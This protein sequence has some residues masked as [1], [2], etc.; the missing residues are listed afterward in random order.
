V[1]EPDHVWRQIEALLRGANTTATLVAPFIKKAVFEAA[2][3][4][5]PSSVERID[6]VTRWTPAEVAAGVSDPEILDVSDKDQRVRVALCPSLHA[7]IYCADDLCLIGSANLTGKATGLAPDANIEL[8]I[9]ARVSHPEVQRVL[10]ELKSAAVPATT[11]M[12][13]LVRQQA[14][15]LNNAV[16]TP[17][18]Q[19]TVS[20]Y[21]VTRR[22]ENL[23]TF[24]SGRSR[25]AVAVE[26]GLVQDLALL[27]VPAGLSETQFNVA[28]HDR[29]HAI[30]ELRKLLV[31]DS[32]SNVELQ[33]AIE[34]RAGFTEGQAQRVVENIAA[35]LKHFGRYYTEVGSWEL[36]HGRELT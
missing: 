7:K 22:P 10:S 30:P 6:C 18:S 21:P 14:E 9:E 33:H 23:F 11:H 24:Y 16:A 35:W 34:E 25:F 29:L 32:L 27:N 4:A 13:A 5:I 20:W 1:T 19:P 15:L 26:A 17:E 12:A 3:A 28:V 2:L 31:G 36:R 8:L